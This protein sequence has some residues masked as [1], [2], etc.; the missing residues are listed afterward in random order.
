MRATSAQLPHDDERWAFEIKWDGM[1]IVSFVRPGAL[2]LQSAN[3]KDATASYP[4]LAHLGDLVGADQAVLDGEVVAFDEEGRPS[5]GRLQQ[6]MHVASAAEA[7]RRAASVPAVY[8]VFD[9]IHVDGH[10]A[11]ALPYGERR[12]LLA[13][14]LTEGPHVVIPG[15]HVGD[16]PAMLEASRRQG[17]EGLLA[18]RV[19]SRYEIG[20]RSQL[21]RK[22]K[23]RY[24][25]ELVVGGWLAGEGG[26]AGFLGALLIGYYEGDELRFAGR[27]GT[28]FSFHELERLGALLRELATD[29]C[30]FTPPPPAATT[31]LAHFVRPELVAEVEFGEWT[32]DGVLRH[33]SYLGLRADKDPRSVVREP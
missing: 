31:R 13:A 20:R 7:R 5:F 12:E 28:G 8:H 25:Q 32:S 6:R 11:T 27:V 16:G 24:R 18:K 2:F 9:V 17:L 21:W 3:L 10:D 15:Y 1:R 14:T 33:P 4:E 19:D 23:N 26:R 22:V 29:E 30:P